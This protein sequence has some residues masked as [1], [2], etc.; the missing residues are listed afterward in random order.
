MNTTAAKPYLT[1]R[2]SL[3]NTVSRMAVGRAQLEIFKNQLRFLLGE[4][5]ENS[6]PET[7]KAAL[8]GFF[9]ENGFGTEYLIGTDKKARIDLHASQAEDGRP[10]AIIS[11]KT[12]ADLAEMPTLFSLNVRAMH[13]LVLHYLNERILG[14]N[15]NLKRLAITNGHEWFLFEAADFERLFG[16][17]T[18][19]AR[20]FR[21]W[22]EGKKS[23]QTPEF[24]YDEL[25]KPYLRNLKN[26]Q[27]PFTYFNLKE[28]ENR[29][30][31]NGIRAE[32]E[33]LIPLLKVLSPTHLLNLESEGITSFCAPF[34]HEL[35]H[36][37]GLEEVKESGKVIIRRCQQ[38]VE[39]SLLERTILKLYEGNYIN[40]PGDR[41]E[42]TN[43]ADLVFSAALELCLTWVNRILFL[44]LLE[45]Q[46]VSY[47]NGDSYK[48][49]LRCDRIPNYEALN[50]LFFQVLACLPEERSATVQKGFGFVPY[51]NS[52]LFEVSELEAQTIQIS[53][54]GNEAVMPFYAETVLRDGQG[55]PVTG[56]A[57]TLHYL[58]D[59]LNAYHFSPES[60]E[61][62]QDEAKTRINAAGLGLI[63]EK[64]N[65]FQ[66]GSF[67]TPGFMPLYMC[68][69]VLRRTVVEKYNEQ[70]AEKEHAVADFAD[71]K[72]HLGSSDISAR[73]RVNDLINNLHICDPAV[74]S[75]RFLVAALNELIAIKADLGV[76]S[77]HDN[78][79]P[80]A[81]YDITLE[82][83]EL[84]VTERDTGKPFAYHLD[85]Q[86]QRPI[87]ALQRMQETLFYEK[88]TLL[89]NCLFGVDINT[90]AVKSCR[91]RLWIELLKNTFYEVKLKLEEPRTDVALTPGTPLCILHLKTLPNLDINIKQGNSLVSRF[92]LGEDLTDVFRQQQ[93][94]HELYIRT[95]QAYKNTTSKAAKAEM[96]DFIQRIK[97]QF[98]TTVS[99][100]DPRRKKLAEFR[101]QLTLL[102]HNV[103]LF[104]N[105]IRS[106][107]NI[108][109]EKERI[110]Q[111][112]D[113]VEEELK[114]DAKAAHYRSAF[115]WRFEFPEV[116][117]EQGNFIGFDVVIGHPPFARAT[118]LVA[119]KLH[120]ARHFNVYA[121]AADLAVYFVE[122]G[123]SLLKQ[124]GH[125]SAII[126]ADSIRV[127]AGKALRRWLQN[128]QITEVHDFGNLPVF[129]RG[130]RSPLILSV[131][132]T[133]RN[134]AA[135]V[136]QVQSL[137]VQDL[138]THLTTHGLTLL[139]E[140]MGDEA[141]QF[142]PEKQQQLW[143]KIRNKGVLLKD[144]TDVSTEWRFGWDVGD[145]EEASEE[146]YYWQALLQ[147]KPTRY[148]LSLLGLNQLK[149]TAK[150]IGLIPI[151]QLL[152]ENQQPFIQRVKAV[153]NAKRQN[154]ETDISAL[155]N[156]IDRLVY[157]VYELTDEEIATVEANT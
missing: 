136:S 127:G 73:Q 47:H 55:R 17:S 37:I 4:V 143:T 131:Q 36:I 44:K 23:R 147:S 45:A 12:P 89:E 63:F 105:E 18:M 42:E 48:H 103:D 65:G 49:F 120:L 51:L 43:A 129:G 16:S 31:S 122:C 90:N 148:Y 88:Q 58:L 39:G 149:A 109:L 98:R 151:P 101:G 92:K 142:V 28:Y 123:L 146:S 145:Q 29:L 57:S 80:V 82:N 102:E 99:L 13:E 7:V 87:P 114:A 66:Q 60:R 86:N 64:L 130:L 94:S 138:K 35:L 14:D 112:L 40:L 133:T 135:V 8:V 24:F 104:G 97:E 21:Q 157:H 27:I 6:A 9:S 54:L 46:I 52:S 93:F 139:P 26:E 79:E 108:A 117:D 116:L 91:L 70:I 118:E 75:G 84:Y 22:H 33:P 155:E 124:G 113:L 150:I 3:E 61:E 5:E 83:E 2:Q 111:R 10:G 59:F 32:D 69:T 153:L 140:F 115:E 100:R 85:R 56:S 128:W 81:E 154:P 20:H 11:V 77:Y 96:L 62:I 134:A 38:P 144:L 74:G 67:Y 19:L 95:V 68:Q 119:L 76:L 72:K 71:L 110:R 1:P 125:F 106:G 50:N 121:S 152:P 156:E 141:W 126:P 25:V 34:Y 78:G 53:Q 15:T 107:E 41:A 137:S 30:T 132:K